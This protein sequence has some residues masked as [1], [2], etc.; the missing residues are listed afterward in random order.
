LILDAGLV[1]GRADAR[2]VDEEAARLRVVEERRDEH[3]AERVGRLDD[4][5]HVVGH[6]GAD[7]RREERPGAVEP[8]A[9]RLGGLHERGPHELVAAERQRDDEHPQSARAPGGRIEHHAHLAEVDLRLLAGGR[10][11]DADRRRLLAPAELL[12]REAP[13]RVVAH[14]Q[15]VAHEQRVYLGQT[16][17]ALLGEPLLDALLVRRDRLPLGARLGQR[18]RLH[19]LRDLVDLT[20]GQLTPLLQRAAL[21]GAHVAAHRLAVDSCLAC[22]AVNTLL[23]RPAA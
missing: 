22:D 12:R 8:L 10:V 3:G 23:R 20:L 5:L 6:D 14:L 4:R 1:L 19:P 11:V 17:R 2:R 9:H 21:C 7:H 13:E 18:T 16:Q 15:A